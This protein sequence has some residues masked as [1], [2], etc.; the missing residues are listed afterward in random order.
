ML[1]ITGERKNVS[2]LGSLVTLF[3]LLFEQGVLRF[4]F[5]LS[6]IN[7]VASPAPFSVTCGHK[8]TS[9]GGDIET[10]VD[11]LGTYC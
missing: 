4:H 11:L 3:F 2:I 10:P 5:V 8:A 6:P 9:N 7:C 1:K